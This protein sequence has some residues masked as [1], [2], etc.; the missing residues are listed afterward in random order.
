MQISRRP[1]IL[2][3]I[4]SLKNINAT[5]TGNL[6]AGAKSAGFLVLTEQKYLNSPDYLLE[7]DI[8]LNDAH[9]VATNVQTGAKAGGSVSNGAII[10]VL[11]LK[12]DRRG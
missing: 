1:D 11:M 10:L 2:L 7:G 9:H 8:L 12:T 6:R 3:R 4:D 5:Y